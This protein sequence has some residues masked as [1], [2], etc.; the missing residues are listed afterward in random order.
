MRINMTIKVA[1]VTTLACVVESILDS[2]RLPPWSLVLLSSAVWVF[3]VYKAERSGLYLAKTGNKAVVNDIAIGM[4]EV[5]D[6]ECEEM[7]QSVEQ[8]LSMVSDASTKVKESFIGMNTETRGHAQVTESLISR[9]NANSE[10]EEAGKHVTFRQFAEEIDEVLQGFVSSIVTVSHESMVIVANIED[11]AIEM[12]EIVGL[13]RAI[14]S[15]GHETHML[16][17]NATI[18]AARAG[19]AGAGFA[20]VAEEVRNLSL[21]TRGASE[22]ITAA[23]SKTRAN[24]E[25]MRSASE[26]MAS[27]DMNVA[28]EAKIRVDE[29]IQD[30]EQLNSL[31][32]SSVEDVSGIAQRIGK[33]V[34]HAVTAMQFE[35]I[36]G[37][38]LEYMTRRAS[39]LRDFATHICLVA[40]AEGPESAAKAIEEKRREIMDLGDFAPDKPVHQESLDTGSTE[41]F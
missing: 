2:A 36:S 13:V 1:L 33:H 16:S 31:I 14:Q 34:N 5:I 39:A 12:N 32:E 26:E 15:V 41:L 28:L 35:D 4:K 27:K 8:V 29:M 10:G 25:S 19:K 21:N 17:L 7:T 38:L 23:V 6:R 30:V 9:M 40:S 18:E 11:V 24:I 37:Q 3:C 20:V 22:K